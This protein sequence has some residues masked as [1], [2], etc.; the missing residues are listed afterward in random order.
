MSELSTAQFLQKQNAQLQNKHD[1]V[2]QAGNVVSG[3][4]SSERM[5][6]LLTSVRSG[7]QSR[8][9]QKV[10]NELYDSL[11]VDITRAGKAADKMQEALDRYYAEVAQLHED[12]ANYRIPGEFR[13]DSV[14][15]N[16]FKSVLKDKVETLNKALERRRQEREVNDQERRKIG[17]ELQE[18]VS[19]QQ[20]L[21]QAIAD[22]DYSRA[23][24][25]PQLAQKIGELRTQL[26]GMSSSV[27]AEDAVINGLLQDSDVRQF[28]F[29]YGG[30]SPKYQI[31]DDRSLAEKYAQQR[32]IDHNLGIK[33]DAAHKRLSHTVY[34]QLEKAGINMLMADYSDLTRLQ[35]AG[36]LT[37]DSYHVIG[38]QALGVLQRFDGLKRDI[39]A[40]GILLDIPTP[41]PTT[42]RQAN[43]NR[44]VD[45]NK[46]LKVADIDKAIGS[47]V[48]GSATDPGLAERRLNRLDRAI[49]EA[50]RRIQEARIRQE[51]INE[52]LT[53]AREDNQQSVDQLESVL[54]EIDTYRSSRDKLNQILFDLH[55]ADTGLSEKVEILNRDDI[56]AFLASR[57]GSL[58][59]VVANDGGEVYRRLNSLRERIKELD[60]A[61]ERKQ[62]HADELLQQQK[63]TK[64]DIENLESD[65]DQVASL[66]ASLEA[67]RQ[68][69]ASRSSESSEQVNEIRDIET[70]QQMIQEIN[71]LVHDTKNFRAQFE[72]TKAFVTDNLNVINALSPGAKKMVMDMLYLRVAKDGLAL[73]VDS[74]DK[75]A[76][77]WASNFKPQQVDDLLSRFNVDVSRL[78][79]VDLSEL[80]GL[81]DEFTANLAKMGGIYDEISPA[82]LDQYLQVLS[83][84][85]GWASGGGIE[86]Y[87]EG[88]DTT[89]VLNNTVIRLKKVLELRDLIAAKKDAIETR[90][91]ELEAAEIKE[92]MEVDLADEKLEA[93]KKKTEELVREIKVNLTSI[94]D[95]AKAL[96]SGE[97]DELSKIHDILD[98]W[99]LIESELYGLNDDDRPDFENLT[100]STLDQIK[101]LAERARLLESQQRDLVVAE[102]IARHKAGFT[103]EKQ[104]EGVRTLRGVDPQ[105]L[106]ALMPAVEQVEVA[107]ISSNIEAALDVMLPDRTSPEGKKYAHPDNQ[108]KLERLL[109]DESIVLSDNEKLELSIF[110]KDGDVQNMID[111]AFTERLTGQR[112]RKYDSDREK[113]KEML[114]RRAL[115]DAI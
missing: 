8:L 89:D 103:K 47:R 4:V 109:S 51:R 63:I 21:G 100:R 20:Q 60:G 64:I 52:A 3:R 11:L 75:Q 113:L 80:T 57:D 28:A 105:F 41:R 36:V 44:L 16:Q 102:L 15:F 98:I 32:N 26:S 42:E 72:A 83:T 81:S 39:S 110:E 61:L 50:D 68:A 91:A 95:K 71:Q 56:R 111:N 86:T 12:T 37:G 73:T 70:A 94:E 93:K 23:S 19:E 34:D 40:T 48:D 74:R 97:T 107:E 45:L 29:T 46:P 84:V 5:R 104:V 96:V 7:E 62:T 58:P 43:I 82:Y 18:R 85:A 65:L 90:R 27:S 9:E 33:K 55:D 49:T 99:D 25:I 13:D 106:R 69:V 87:A 108:K 2:H 6:S 77:L 17:S 59:P 92:L 31:L 14:E 1:D 35:D 24:E 114:M 76:D 38:K 79:L 115:S 88:A 30:E 54:A 67:A 66:I 78:Q 53:S 112:R 10:G 101:R 22:G